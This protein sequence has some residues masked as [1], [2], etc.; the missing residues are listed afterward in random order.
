MSHVLIVDDERDL[1]EL[2]DFNLKSAGFSTQVAST[3]E[4]ALSAARQQRPDLVLLDL[5]L[6]D[7]PG[8]EVCR[9]LRA[10]ANT[11]DI[12]IVMLTAKGEEA[13]RVLGFEVGADDYVTKPFSVRELVL[14]LKAILRR[15]GAPKDS[16]APVTLGS[17]KL[18]VGAH[19]FYVEGKE[20]PL[21]ALEFRLLE[22]LMTRVGRVQS[23]EQLLEE[24]WG[25]SSA[26]ETRTIDTHVMRLRDKLG[27]ARTS[28]ETVRG[29]GYRIVDSA[30]S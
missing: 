6:P 22:Y 15:S 1:A 21:T 20:V 11:R 10:G 29:V 28:L 13:D 23:R 30:A 25:L 24:V 9:Q 16:V 2:I 27:P 19:R 26:L 8:T 12:L 17:L 18:D 7:M 4:A 5:M 3:G 14:R